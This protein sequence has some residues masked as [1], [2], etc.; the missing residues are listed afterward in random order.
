MLN[1]ITV[2]QKICNKVRFQ[3]H[4]FIL[5]PRLPEAN[6]SHEKRGAKFYGNGKGIGLLLSLKYPLMIE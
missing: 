5:C 2:Y 6:D 4:E 3:T 1:L